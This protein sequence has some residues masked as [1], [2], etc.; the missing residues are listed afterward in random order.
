MVTVATLSRAGYLYPPRWTNIAQLYIRFQII[1]ASFP[2]KTPLPNSTPQLQK[3]RKAQRDI[4]GIL[5]SEGFEYNPS[6]EASIFYPKD[7]QSARDYAAS[8]TRHSTGFKEKG[9]GN[10]RIIVK[11]G[12]ELLTEE[13]KAFFSFEME[14]EN[15][16]KMTVITLLNKI[17]DKLNC[18]HLEAFKG[19]FGPRLR[20]L[21][22]KNVK[23]NPC[24]LDD[25]EIKV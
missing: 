9:K 16:K 23:L 17:E 12:S 19:H 15:P 3:W 4:F 13:L 2:K 20:K 1:D 14:V 5:L 7:I 24:L 11:N 8:R 22:L 21:L 10:L 6:Y 18:E 25:D